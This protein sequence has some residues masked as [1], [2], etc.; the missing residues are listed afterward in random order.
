[1][2]LKA[3]DRRRCLHL[4]AKLDLRL[5]WLCRHTRGVNK[6]TFLQAYEARKE[7]ESLEGILHVELL[8]LEKRLSHPRGA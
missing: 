5:K 8:E 4:L 7:L 2:Q 1:M 3:A 6:E